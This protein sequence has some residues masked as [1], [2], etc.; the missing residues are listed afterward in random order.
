MT[1]ANI[2]RALHLCLSNLGADWQKTRIIRT[3]VYYNLGLMIGKIKRLWS[4]LSRQTG[5]TPEAVAWAYRMILGRE[6]SPAEIQAHCD[7]PD[8][9]ALRQAFFSSQEFRHRERSLC[10]SLH[11]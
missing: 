1:Y 5:V 9:Q 2:P 6:P 3:H 11:G 8:L 10:G 4:R 7:H